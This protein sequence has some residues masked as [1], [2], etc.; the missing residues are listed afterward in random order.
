MTAADAQPCGA[1][2]EI[3]L[4]QACGEP[5]A[6][7]VT[8][9]CAHGHDRTGWTCGRHLQQM[10]D[11]LTFCYRCFLATHPCRVFIAHFEAVTADA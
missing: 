1:V 6:A 5:A 9:R 3:D 11:G 8:A 7:K 2:Q 4:G 10:R